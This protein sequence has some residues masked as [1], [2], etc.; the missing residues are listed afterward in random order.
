MPQI[1]N[2]ETLLDYL[3]ISTDYLQSKGID[4]PRLNVQLMLCHILK[5]D[6]IALYMKYDYP[7]TKEEISTLREFLKRRISREPLQHILGETQFLDFTFKVS[8]DVLIPRPETEELV[9][10]A[11][12]ELKKIQNPVILEIGT[13]SGIIPIS[14]ARYLSGS[15]IVAIDISEEAIL[16][17]KKNAFINKVENQI[18]FQIRN[19]LTE[20]ITGQFDCIISNP[21]YISKSEVNQLEPEVKNFEPHIALT[22][23]NDG[24]DFYRKF[25]TAITENLKSGGLIFLE[26]NESL[27]EESKEI[28]APVLSHSEIIID[29]QNKPRIF[30]GVK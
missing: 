9:D 29:M 25:K 28:L 1:Q 15:K 13:G 12:K 5:I 14:M 10:Y 17:A 11:I 6:K 23:G 30:K 4:D 26:L 18:D 8:K 3:T 24:L 2:P 20:N 19:F 21:P 7:L 27:A 22:D 16:I